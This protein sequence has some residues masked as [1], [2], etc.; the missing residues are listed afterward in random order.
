MQLGSDEELK[1]RLSLLSSDDL[2]RGLFHNS[3]L[4]LV[5]RLEGDEAVKECL[6][7][8]G[9]ARFLDFFNYAHYSYIKLLYAAARRMSDRFG[10]FERAM[11]EIGYAG[12]KAFYASAA[13]KVLILM[14]QGDPRRL[15]TNIPTGM[16][17]ASKHVELKV[18]LTGP[19]SGIL[20]KREVMPRPHTEGGLTAMCE[21]AKVKGTKVS[22]RSLSPN[23]NE[24]VVTWD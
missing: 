20:A 5:R 9:E 4:E 24:Y 2:M 22:S 17:M 7:A 19:R 10:G 23:E 15:L 11:W 13:G 3:V 1:W 14:A 6:A 12:G 16:Q 21:V 8:C 18:T